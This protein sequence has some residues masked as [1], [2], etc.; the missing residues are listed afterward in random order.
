MNAIWKYYL[1][2]F[3]WRFFVHLKMGFFSVNKEVF[4]IG[5]SL[6]GPIRGTRSDGKLNLIYICKGS[7]GPSLPIGASLYE[8]IAYP[9]LYHI[10]LFHRLSCDSCSACLLPTVRPGNTLYN[11]YINFYY[12]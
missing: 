4:P 9:T 10:V 11:M 5:I 8:G 2:H 1:L 7:F 6:C 12:Y 3:L